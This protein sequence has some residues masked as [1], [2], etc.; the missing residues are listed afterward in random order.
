MALVGDRSRPPA[1]AA[2][3]VAEGHAQAEAIVAEIMAEAEGRARTLSDEGARAEREAGKLT[4]RAQYLA[5]AA[6][7]QGQ[8]EA[9]ELA[10]A[11]L[12]AEREDLSAQAAALNGTLERLAADREDV[13][14]QLAAAREAADVP[15][16][17]SLRARE[18]A[19]GEVIASLRARVDAAQQH[20]GTRGV[21]ELCTEH[22]AALEPWIAARALQRGAGAQAWIAWARRRAQEVQVVRRMFSDR[23]GRS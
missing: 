4:E 2:R 22:L 13:A 3:V 11:E 16:I 9:A 12:A 8:A 17:A 10:A 19:A 6:E 21:P 23:V 18:A 1:G 14:A 5:R 20:A 7:A 15:V